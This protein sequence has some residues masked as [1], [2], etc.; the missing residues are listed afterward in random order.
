[1]ASKKFLFVLLA[2]ALFAGVL[3]EAGDTT[4][5]PATTSQVPSTSSSS[6]STSTEPET[7]TTST[8]TSTTTTTTTA[9]PPTT[10]PPT[11]APTTVAPPTP[12]PSPVPSDPRGNW[13]VT[14]DNVT[15][16]IAQMIVTAKID[17]PLETV[18][19]TGKAK[20]S[21]PPTAKVEGSCDP[22][23]QWIKLT[24][25]SNSIQVDFKKNDSTKMYFISKIDFTFIADP[26]V[27]Q[28]ISQDFANKSF[29]FVRV[30]QDFNINLNHSFRCSR[31]QDLPLDFAPNK[32]DTSIRA[33][34][35]IS[36][37]QLQAFH[38]DKP[39]VFGAAQ[40]C[41]LDTPDIVPIA[42]G[43]ALAALVCV[44]LVAYLVGRRRS[45]ARGYLS[46]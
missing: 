5:A 6:P 43:C 7:T 30:K 20:V 46:M 45:Q 36:S 12:A 19:Q 28:N 1:M 17:Y 14:G 4:V 13:T 21:V 15:C 44:V 34:L 33:E 3:G 38:V 37:V 23:S 27:F 18:N 42:V 8:T 39:V 2:C 31:E 32:N 35:A 10:P 9:A 25:D 41:E 24:W 11:P 26:T 22:A 40:D 29:E 16:I